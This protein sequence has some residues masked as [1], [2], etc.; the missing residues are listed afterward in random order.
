MIEYN[1]ASGDANPKD[2][3]R[4]TFDQLYAT[5]HDKYGMDDQ[6]GWKNIPNA[7]F[8]FETQA[9]KK[10]STVAKYD[11]WWLANPHDGLYNAVA[12]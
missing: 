8:A 11:A 12:R 3:R 6:V 10:W 2:G 7:R 1:Y 4:G 5:A 9:S